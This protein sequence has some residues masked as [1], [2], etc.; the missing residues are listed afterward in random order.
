[1]PVLIDEM[2]T[3]LR[4]GYKVQLFPEAT[5]RC[6]GAV[7]EFH[8]AGFQAAIDAAVVVMPVTLIYRDAH[9]QQ[10]AAA[11]FVGDESLVSAIRR[12]VAL[13]AMSVDVHLAPTDPGHRRHRQR[14]KDRA[15][16][17]TLVESAIAR[18]LQVSDHPPPRNRTVATPVRPTLAAPGTMAG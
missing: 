16:I 2:T 1:M 13:P 17:T 14:A 8:R 12:A 11:A 3:A 18:D 6:G 4:Q 9:G 10:T 5:T 15:R 7:A